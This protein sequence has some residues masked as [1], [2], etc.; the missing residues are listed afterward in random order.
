MYPCNLC[1]EDTGDF[2][3]KCADLNLEKKRK[4]IDKK[5]INRTLNQCWYCSDSVDNRVKKYYNESNNNNS[6][7]FEKS[8]GM[9]D[10]CSDH[11]T[12]IENEDRKV[13]ICPGYCYCCGERR[14]FHLSECDYCD[15][16]CCNYCTDFDKERRTISCVSCHPP[17]LMSSTKSGRWTNCCIWFKK[18]NNIKFKKK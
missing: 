6:K 4:I 1:N 9:C 11:K 18:A 10:V 15:R 14:G 7:E 2:C 12:K 17:V 3:D 5:R 13:G 16:T 8:K